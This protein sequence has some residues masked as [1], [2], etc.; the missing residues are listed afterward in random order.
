MAQAEAARATA[1]RLIWS[2]SASGAMSEMK[3]PMPSRTGTG[4]TSRAMPVRGRA[5]S[6][7][8]GSAATTAIP[9][10][11]RRTRVASFSRLGRRDSPS[12]PAEAWRTVPSFSCQTTA[13]PVISASRSTIAAVPAPA[14]ASSMS[15]VW[16]SCW[17]SWSRVR[18]SRMKR[19]TVCWMSLRWEP[20]GRWRSGIIIRSATATDSIDASPITATATP[21]LSPKLWIT[22][23]RSRRSS[24][25]RIE[26]TGTK[27]ISPPLMVS[28]AGGRVRSAVAHSTRRSSPPPPP[29]SSVPSGIA[30]LQTSLTVIIVRAVYARSR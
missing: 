27:A 19:T 20:S 30:P 24:R 5:N 11:Q 9:S 28:N 17:R 10:A 14:R 25:R 2:R 3:P 21:P 1:S 13:W 18:W 7:T 23:A 29:S 6:W 22:W 15:W 12:A 26:R 8:G 16:S 4:A